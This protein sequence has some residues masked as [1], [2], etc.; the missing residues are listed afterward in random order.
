MSLAPR[1]RSSV[2]LSLLSA[3]LRSP[4]RPYPAAQ[5]GADPERAELGGP[6]QPVCV[7]PLGPG[8][9]AD[10]VQGRA[11]QEVDQLERG[12]DQAVGDHGGGVGAL[13]LRFLMPASA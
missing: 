10:P 7:A 3:F 6:A 12:V 5:P 11:G 4:W 13:A 9:P 1:A 8:A 2:A